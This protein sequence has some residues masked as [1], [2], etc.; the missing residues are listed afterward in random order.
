MTTAIPISPPSH[1]DFTT[2]IAQLLREAQQAL[3]ASAYPELQQV[4]VEVHLGEVALRGT[5][6]S[7]FQKQ[8][9]QEL[10]KHVPG[11]TSLQNGLVV[12]P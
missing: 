3:A 6:P 1:A 2:E 11:I 10:V 12:A 7:Y 4:W 5:V 8:L 9:A